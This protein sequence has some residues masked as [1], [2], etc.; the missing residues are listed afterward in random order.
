MTEDGVR[1]IKSLV[2]EHYTDVECIWLVLDNLST[3]NPPAL[4]EYL[5]PPEARRL[6]SKVEFHFTPVHGRWLNMA[7]IDFNAHCGQYLERR[8]LDEATLRQEVQAGDARRN[9]ADADIQWQF[10]SVD[11]PL[12]LHRLNPQIDD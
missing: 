3:H 4:Y 2:D 5:E 6:L 8:I 9:E 7:E 12:K 10:T 11:T 1:F